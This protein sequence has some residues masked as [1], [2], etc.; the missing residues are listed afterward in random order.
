LFLLKSQPHAHTSWS[1]GN[2][3]GNG[4]LRTGGTLGCGTENECGQLT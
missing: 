3:V 1:L 2:G 4:A